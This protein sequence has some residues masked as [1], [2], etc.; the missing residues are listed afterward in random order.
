MRWLAVGLSA[1]G[2]AATAGAVASQGTPVQVTMPGKVFAPGELDV[3]VGTRVTWTNGDSAT[4]TV[5]AD[6]EAFDSG[7]LR[8]GQ[9]FGW[10]FDRTGSF[11]YRCSIHR[12]MRGEVRV[13]ALVLR[14]PE[15]AVLPGFAA[16]VAGQAPPEAAEL[17]VERV[18][19][20]AVVETGRIVPGPD[21]RFAFTLR[22]P[23]PA[24][25]RVRAGAATSPV[26]RV[27]IRPHVALS[28][29]GG[30]FRVAARPPRPHS[31]VALQAYDRE[32]F[33]WVT[34]GRGRLDASS[35]ERLVIA[36]EAPV[37]VRAV[38]RGRGG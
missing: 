32:R 17:V 26:V 19:P 28:R 8:S 27:P 37:H 9:E 20:G 15:R 38:V 36:V 7:Y 5:T 14:G 2:L 11:A 6:G 33:R 24:A 30:T 22:V 29:D 10:T 3:L 18:A 35:R 1:L 23:G 12:F 16:R 31:R 34:V 25:Y 21:G 4:H 13:Y